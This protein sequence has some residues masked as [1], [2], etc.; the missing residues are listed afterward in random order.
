VEPETFGI[1]SST[2]PLL[3]EA[4]ERAVLATRFKPAT[5][6]GLAVRQLVQQPFTFAP[7]RR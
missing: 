3:A 4:V 5:R 2:H 7:P 1:A 6:K